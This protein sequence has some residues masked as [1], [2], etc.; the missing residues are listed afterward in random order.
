M[1]YFNHAFKKTFLGTGESFDDQ[2]FTDPVNGTV[3]SISTNGGYLNTSNVPTYM[4]NEMSN[5]QK[6]YPYSGPTDLSTWRSGYFGLFDAKTNLS[7]R[8]PEEC[9]NLYIAGSAIYT[10]DKIGPFAGGYTETNKSKMIN[11]RYVQQFYYVDSCAPQNEVVHVG[12]TFWTAGGGVSAATITTPGVGYTNTATPV[13]SQT[14][15]TSGTG[16]GLTVFVTVAAGVPTVTGIASLGKG[17]EVGDTVTITDWDGGAPGT[18]AIYTIN[19]VNAAG[20]NYVVT[21]GN[22]CKEFL[23][24]E[25]YY[26]RVDIKGSPALRFLNHNAY[27]TAE[28]YTGCCTDP[29]APSAVDS[30]EVM[31]LWANALLRYELTRPFLQIVI[32]DEAGVLWYAPG[33]SAADLATLGGDTWDN[34][35]AQPHVDGACA[36]MIFNG[37]Y[38]DTKFGDCTFQ[39]TDFYEKQPVKIFP[40]EVDLN[41]DPCTFE[42]ICAV[43]ECEGTQAQGLGE[44]VLRDLVLSESYRQNFLANNDL[45]IREIT[46]GN[47]LI[48]A[49]NRNALYAKYYLL[50]SVPRFNNPTGVFDNDRYLL[51]VILWERNNTFE[52]AVNDWLQGCGTQCAFEEFNCITECSSITFPPIPPAPPRRG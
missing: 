18:L 21:A 31:I 23:C 11:P 49:I 41:G 12:S 34:Y 48:T 50:H 30:T 22:C 39:L 1:A 16:T 44:Q 14:V 19:T 3:Y 2:N 47:Q 6:Q 15:T 36:G 27:Y 52:E 10:N 33:T 8:R 45:R 13:L 20:T 29:I 51:E 35:V 9:C 4:L 24:G 28:A 17:Y 46:Q 38:V 5:Y 26:L 37:A 42:G 43:I 32:Q 40:S 7:E 25:T